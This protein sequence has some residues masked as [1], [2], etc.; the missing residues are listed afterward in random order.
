[1]KDSSFSLGQE[2]KDSVIPLSYKL[3]DH[4]SLAIQPLIYEDLNQ[5][6]Y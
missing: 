1:M 3:K 6:S 4:H 2:I 5:S